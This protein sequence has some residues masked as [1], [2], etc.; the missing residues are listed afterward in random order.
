MAYKALPV[1]VPVELDQRLTMLARKTHRSKSFYIRE[2]L[3]NYL[4][5]VEDTYL[6]LQAL[7]EKGRNYS[8]AEVAREIGLTKDEEKEIGLDDKV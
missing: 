6:A 3:M 5:E 1:K 7:E 2:A 8:I 4:E